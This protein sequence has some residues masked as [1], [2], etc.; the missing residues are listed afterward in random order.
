MPDR[1]EE[2]PA[3]ARLEMVMARDTYVSGEP[4]EQVEGFDND[5]FVVVQH[6]IEVR[7]LI[8][9]QRL[10][11]DGDN[12]PFGDKD[13]VVNLARAA[14]AKG[15][16]VGIHTY[17]PE[18][19]CLVPLLGLPNVVIEKTHAKVRAALDEISQNQ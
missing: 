2:G 19:P 16:W 10:V 15:L 8:P 6:P 17:Y 1:P 13:A 12:V 18:A 9:G 3:Q 14:A 7:A 11:M 4:Q 5:Y